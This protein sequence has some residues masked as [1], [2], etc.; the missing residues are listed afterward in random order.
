MVSP[1]NSNNLLPASALQT[2]PAPLGAVVARR[3]PTIRLELCTHF[4]RPQAPLTHMLS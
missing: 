3:L 4:R 2:V 1:K